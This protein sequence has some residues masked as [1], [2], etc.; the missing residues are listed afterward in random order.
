MTTLCVDELRGVCVC[1]R[2]H[3]Q[4]RR[5]GSISHRRRKRGNLRLH[6]KEVMDLNVMIVVNGSLNYILDEMYFALH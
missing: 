4:T 2:C 1:A 5:Q 3:S 6:D